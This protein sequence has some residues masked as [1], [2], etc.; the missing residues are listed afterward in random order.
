MAAA[1]PCT[2]CL[3]DALGSWLH[4]TWA[5]SGVAT[6]RRVGRFTFRVRG[7]RRTLLYRLL[8][9][10]TPPSKLV[11]VVGS[12]DM[13]ALSELHAAVLVDAQRRHREHT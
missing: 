3:A 4:S 10:R 6:V 13:P 7:G 12:A 11:L 2:T 5:A 9:Y 1:S 8:P